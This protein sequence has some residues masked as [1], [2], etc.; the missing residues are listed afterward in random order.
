MVPP[1]LAEARCSSRSACTAADKKECRKKE[2]TLMRKWRAEMILRRGGKMKANL[3]MDKL[4]CGGVATVN[5]DQWK[6]EVEEHCKNKYEDSNRDVADALAEV[7]VLRSLQDS[8]VEILLEDMVQ[9]KAKLS[10]DKSNGGC[11]STVNEWIKSLPAVMM[12]WLLIAFNARLKGKTV[13]TM[14]SWLI[15]TLVFLNK[16][17]VPK[18]MKD[19]RGIG[20]LDCFSIF[21]LGCLMSMAE[22]TT[23]LEHWWLKVVS[24]AYA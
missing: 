8:A 7:D 13:E 9:A 4:E 2:R 6:T 1:D 16:T 18:K 12:Y 17:Q 20:L 15:M 10:K 11:S 19:F 22:R 3:T 24:V 14:R 5:R 21:Y 23:R